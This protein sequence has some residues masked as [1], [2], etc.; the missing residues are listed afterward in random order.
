M[1]VSFS[2][3]AEQEVVS[4]LDNF[5]FSGE[6][7]WAQF[8]PLP[9]DLG[10]LSELGR[11]EATA[12]RHLER[13]NAELLEELELAEDADFR[14]AVQHNVV[15]LQRKYANLAQISERVGWS[16][17]LRARNTAVDRGCGPCGTVAV[18]SLGVGQG[19]AHE[20]STELNPGIRSD[21]VA[22]TLL[23][24]QTL[25]QHVK[26]K[27]SE[28]ED[29]LMVGDLG[30][31][32]IAPRWERKVA[33]RHEAAVMPGL[34]G[35]PSESAPHPLQRVSEDA[36]SSEAPARGGGEGVPDHA[37]SAGLQDVSDFDS[38]HAGGLAAVERL[39]ALLRGVRRKAIEL[40]EDVIAG[41]LRSLSVSE[42]PVLDGIAAP[43]TGSWRWVA[44]LTRPRTRPKTAANL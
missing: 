4:L 3:L 5:E 43:E 9:E 36:S 44:D 29:D 24:M 32:A 7:G 30:S 31:L 10:V 6:F 17:V 27:A 33:R 25:L 21:D 35:P 28:L 1:E 39:G 16:L 23:R 18:G 2:R 19:S 8:S 40:E 12:I 38:G 22:T 26:R 41:S 15:V 11:A 20:C 14:A 13:S 34:R 37:E 42:L